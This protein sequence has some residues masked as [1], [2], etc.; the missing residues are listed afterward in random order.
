MRPSAINA[1]AVQL[2]FAIDHRPSA[3][4][5][6][7]E[8]DVVDRSAFV[9]VLVVKLTMLGPQFG[10]IHRLTF[11]RLHRSALGRTLWLRA[12]NTR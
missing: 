6:R 11:H 2:A 10:L 4:C 8:V 9:C 7:K 12:L 1:A 3:H 5:S